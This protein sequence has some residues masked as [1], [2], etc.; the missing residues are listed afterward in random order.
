MKSCEAELDHSAVVYI[1]GRRLRL[2]T[3]NETLLRELNSRLT[4]KQRKRVN[5][6]Y[7][8]DYKPAYA[9]QQRTNYVELVTMSGMIARIQETAESLLIPLIV[10]D[11]ER[12]CRVDNV[13]MLP[14]L[15]YHNIEKE[16]DSLREWTK[17]AL[18]L[19][20]VCR[21]GR[22]QAATG[23]GKSTLIAKFCRLA[24]DSKILVTTAGIGNLKNLHKRIMEEGVSVDLITGSS[25]VRF[26]KGTDAR[27][28]CVSTTSLHR[29]AERKF[30][31]VLGDEIHTQAAQKQREGLW[32]INSPRIFGFD[33]NQDDRPD[34]GDLWIESIYGPLILERSY[35]E[36]QAQ[37]DVVPIKVKFLPTSAQGECKS[38]ML[39][40]RERY[41]I[42]RNPNRNADIVEIARKSMQ[43]GHQVLILV[44]TTEHCLRIK[45]LMPEIVPVYKRIAP[46]RM[47]QLRKFGLLNFEN[48]QGLSTKEISQIQSDFAS[49]KIKAAVAN[50]VWHVGQDF[51]SLDVLIR[52]DASVSKISN[53]QL[54][55]RISRVFPDKPYGLVYDFTDSFDSAFKSRAIV[56]RRFYKSQGWEVDFDDG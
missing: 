21:M 13:M 28:V 45:Q 4:V 30:D 7:V 40:L 32:S 25:D 15:R 24:I 18:R 44:K 1:C 35:T 47:E 48:S 42:V 5:G 41:F 51:P 33:A 9:V 31:V 23:G 20:R 2:V 43:V 49:R 46:S 55:G 26:M 6:R 52:A 38:T 22:I 36:N 56:R 17:S 14:P 37:G 8:S 29:V 53:T 11:T 54:M 19:M 10:V 3:R 16:W 12:Q 27:V 50:S 39:S 34:G